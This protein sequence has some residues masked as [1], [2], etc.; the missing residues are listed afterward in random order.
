MTTTRIALIFLKNDSPKLVPLNAVTPL[1]AEDE[2]KSW[3]LLAPVVPASL[4]AV[5]AFENLSMVV[6]IYVC[7]TYYQ[8]H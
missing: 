1:S 7:V 3:A 6:Y 8:L 2:K 4:M 5:N